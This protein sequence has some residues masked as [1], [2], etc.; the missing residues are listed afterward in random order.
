MKRIFPFEDKLNGEA[1]YA[2]CCLDC[3]IPAVRHCVHNGYY[4][5]CEDMARAVL[6]SGVKNNL[7]EGSSIFLRTP[8]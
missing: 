2:V 6:E 1:V 8:T 7:E 4:Y 5:F 3:R